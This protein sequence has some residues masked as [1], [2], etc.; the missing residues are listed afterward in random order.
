MHNIIPPP[1]SYLPEV[2]GHLDIMPRVVIELPI[3]R[4]HNSLKGSRAE[5]DHKGDSA[6]L[7]RQVDV[8]S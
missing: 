6:V 4:L 2:A 8:V 3:Y 7:Q 5:V 1:L